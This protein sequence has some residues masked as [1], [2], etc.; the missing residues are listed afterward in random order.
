[1]LHLLVGI[2]RRGPAVLASGCAIG[3]LLP[4]SAE[5][6][7]P[8]LP[9][10]VFIFV[11]GTLLRIDNREVV[12]AVKNLKV[13]V[14]FPL[15]MVAACP[16]LFGM[17][18]YAISGNQELSLAIAVA[19]AAP[20]ASGNVAVARM[21]GLDPSMSLVVVLCSMVLIPVTAP[22][23]LHV[24]GNGL[25]LLIDPWELA[26]RLALLIG[27]AEGVAI[28]IRHFSHDIVARH[29]LAIDGIVVLALFIFSI[30]T[31]AGLQS[32][33]LEKPVGVAA[34]IAVAYGV[35]FVLQLMFGGLYPGSLM[36]KFTMAL[37][38]GNRN[39]GLLWSALGVTVSPTMALY[40][41]CCQLPIHTM[42]KILQFFLP[43]IER[44]CKTRGGMRVSEPGGQR[45]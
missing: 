39:V 29:G 10:M 5:A 24:F 43:K 4:S 6:A 32:T 21:L 23:V 9:M 2:T 38:G 35:N 37:N 1:M 7:R 18:A 8:L 45:D 27:G 33:I 28:L 30:G 15:L 42:P 41:A 31:M 12:I 26:A 16:Y 40:F 3:L 20:P 34:M 13:S 36:S 11:L 22:A 17:G 14:I 25:L 44:Y 19:V